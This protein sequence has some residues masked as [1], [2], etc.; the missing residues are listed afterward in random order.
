M[1]FSQKLD[2]FVMGLIKNSKINTIISYV[3]NIIWQTKKR[4]TGCL[5]IKTF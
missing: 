2:N 3:C 5:I 4:Y 1:I